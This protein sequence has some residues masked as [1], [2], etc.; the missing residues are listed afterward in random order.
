M[1][2]V[3][4]EET[5]R[6]LYHENETKLDSAKEIAKKFTPTQ[7][8]VTESYMHRYRDAERP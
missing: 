2:E 5:G 7:D 3:I 8:E 1:P 4:E 6:R